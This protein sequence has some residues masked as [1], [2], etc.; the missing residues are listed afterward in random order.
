MSIKK[1]ALDWAE[2]M[3]RMLEEHPDRR[4]RT[5]EIKAAG[6]DVRQ[7]AEKLMDIYQEQIDK[8]AGL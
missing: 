2:A 5:E 4:S 7:V 3:L 6:F 8:Q 1:P